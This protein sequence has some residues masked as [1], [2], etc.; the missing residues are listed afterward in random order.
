M[1]LL[2][3]VGQIFI[4]I[5]QL[6]INSKYLALGEFGRRIRARKGQYFVEKGIEDYQKKLKR[7]IFNETNNLVI[8]YNQYKSFIGRSYG[9][10]WNILLRFCLL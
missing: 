6:V 10:Q 8:I 5:A 2:K 7:T 9:I 3:K 1:N 4:T